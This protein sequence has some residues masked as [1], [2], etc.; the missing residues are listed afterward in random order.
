VPL[1]QEKSMPQ[2]CSCLLLFVAF[3]PIAVAQDKVRAFRAGAFAGDITPTKFPV[4]VNGGMSD[5]QAT[6]AHDRL[7]ARTLVLDDGATKLALVVCDSCMIPREIAD[8]A[9]ALAHKA[10]GIPPECILISATHTHTAPTLRGAFQSEPSEDYVKELPGMIAAAIRKADERL[11]PAKVGWAV[12]K[13]PTQVFNRRWK[14]KPGSPLRDDPFGRST[15]RVR[16]N[17][18]Y[19]HPDIIEPAG[20]TDPDITLLSVQAPDGRPV[21]LVANYSLHYVGGLPALSADY[22]GAYAEKMRELIGGDKAFVGIMANGTSGDINNINFGGPAPPKREE[23]EQIRIVTDSVAKA[24]LAAYKTIKHHD[25]VSLAMAQKEIDLGVRR[26]TEAEILR[27]EDMLVKA[28]KKV[29]VTLPEVYARETVFMAKFPPKVKLV[30]QAIRIGELGI[31]ANPCE[32][33]VEIGLEI[34]QKSPLRPTCTIEL[35]NGYNGYLP[36]PEHHALGGYETWR[37]RSSYLEV[38]ASRAITDTLL[39]LLKQVAKKE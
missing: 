38:N 5:R 7:H 9:K 2:I 3:A 20:P 24:S 31:V 8:A 6:A 14:I 25:W 11:A 35:A 21:A 28:N 29:L 15:D 27:A 4:S 39:G 17:P 19:Q 22:F 18:G 13:D 12:G 30:L 32:T 10:T 34:K 37:A 23:G 16:M 36:T 26:P 1:V 33:F